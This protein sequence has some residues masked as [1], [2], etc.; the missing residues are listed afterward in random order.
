VAQ[1]VC[2]KLGEQLWKPKSGHRRRA[3]AA[4]PFSEYLKYE[5]TCDASTRFWAS[6]DSAVDLLGRFNN[7]SPASHSRYPGLCTNSAPFSTGS[8]QDT[9]S[10]WQISL[11]VNNQTLTG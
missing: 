3:T 7:I 1:G 6:S 10:K 5:G 8:T 9:N 4:L 2:A 11:D